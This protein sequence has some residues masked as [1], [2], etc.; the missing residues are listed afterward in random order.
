MEMA[1]QTK[2]QQF[3][4]DLTVRIRERM[5]ILERTRIQLKQEFFGIDRVID[6]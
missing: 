6:K 5:E 3:K 1:K 2:Q 4:E